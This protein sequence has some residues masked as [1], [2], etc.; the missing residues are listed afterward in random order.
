MLD[1]IQKILLICDASYLK[2]NFFMVKQKMLFHARNSRW[3][4]GGC[5][6][7]VSKNMYSLGSNITRDIGIINFEFDDDLKNMGKNKVKIVSLYRHF[8]S[9]I[10]KNV[11]SFL[12]F[13]FAVF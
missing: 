7:R 9:Y 11:R 10:Y 8:L 4:N 1:I 3:Q 6:I 13:P 5:Y 12:K 2:W